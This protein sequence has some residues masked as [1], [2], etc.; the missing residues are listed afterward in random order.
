[1]ERCAQKKW[2]PSR[3]NL[4]T[5]PAITYGSG[6]HFWRLSLPYY[7]QLSKRQQSVRFAPLPAGLEE[8]R[9]VTQ[10][11]L[12]DALRRAR[13]MQ[14]LDAK[15]NVVVEAQRYAD[16][17]AQHPELTRTQ[18]A[19]ALGV[20]RVR[21]FQMLSI[22]NL[23]APVIEFILENDTAEYRAILTERRLRPLTHLEGE[24]EQVRGFGQLLAGTGGRSAVLS[25]A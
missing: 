13:R 25:H 12:R 9:E 21:V 17:L 1:M 6:R 22:L 8:I 20:S 3:N 24:A 4:R 7:V 23:P 2:L 14:E 5:S 10:R 19:E 11:Q 16:A 15:P 18:L